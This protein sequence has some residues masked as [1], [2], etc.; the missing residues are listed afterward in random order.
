MREDDRTDLELVALAQAGQMCDAV[1]ILV[2]R[3]TPLVRG[4]VYPMVLNHTDADDVTQEAMVKVVR[5]LGSFKG[6]A[7]FSTWVYRIAA[8]TTLN[9]IKRRR[10]QGLEGMEALALVQDATAEQ[11]SRRLEA[12]ETDAAISRAMSKL[13]PEQRMAVS[14]VILQDMDEG[15]AAAVAGC[16]AATLRWRLHAAR[17]KLKI[18]LKDMRAQK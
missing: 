14:L 12:E 16:R 11:P 9:F 15:E 8:N 4:V 5:S 17:K 7:S 2:K 3:H 6:N 1:A 18:L 10:P 13:S